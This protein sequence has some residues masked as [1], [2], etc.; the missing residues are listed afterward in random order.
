MA[1]HASVLSSLELAQQLNIPHQKLVDVVTLNGLDN[2]AERVVVSDDLCILLFNE[3]QQV[4][5]IECLL[6]GSLPKA[7]NYDL[8]VGKPEPYYQRAIL[9]ASAHLVLTESTT[10]VG[11]I[12]VLTKTSVLEIK[13]IDDWKHGL[14][15]VL[16]YGT[17]YPAHKKELCLHGKL[18]RRRIAVIQYVC[19]SNAVTLTLAHAPL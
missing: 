11:R 9:A 17:F 19:Y 14:G 7:F 3:Q 12:D 8:P 13:R 6:T 4:D 15:Q 10:P 16:A 5:C 2:R 18:D 1:R